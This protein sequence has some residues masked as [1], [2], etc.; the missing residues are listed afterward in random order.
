MTDSSNLSN[1]KNSKESRRIDSAMLQERKDK[2]IVRRL[3]LEE[4]KEI[5]DNYND[6]EEIPLY[7]TLSGAEGYDI[8]LLVDE[9]LLE[10]TE[11]GAISAKHKHRVVAVESN[12]L[13]ISQL[14]K[15]FAGLNIIT[16]PIKDLLR[17]NSPTKFPDKKHESLC[18][19][20]I[21]NLDFNS[22]L[23]CLVLPDGNHEFP[24]VIWI[25]KFA[26]LHKN[27]Q[28]GN[29]WRLCV[30]LQGQINWSP[31]IC[32]TT[33]E[34]LKENFNRSTEFNEQGKKFLG[35]IL[36]QSILDSA[37]IDFK[38]I[39]MEDQQKIIM[40]FLPKKIIFATYNQGWMIKTKYNLSYGGT[41]ASAPMVTWIF[42]FTADTRIN[43]NP[44]DLYLSGVQ[45]ILSSV[46]KIV[47]DGIIDGE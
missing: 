43:S 45:Q 36:H 10:L 4:L 44:D 16:M 5:A 32:R 22:S 35:D 25:H 26:L 17:G 47:E 23:E 41:N 3:W 15:K 40:V 29:N 31:D 39:S 13:A 46:G 11:T 6:A 38:K 18:K 9:G 12:I 1:H 33:Q 27:Q 20:K 21:V 24:V 2:Q 7:L 8:R 34:F 42:D 14:Q 19:A 28:S 37:A 30:T